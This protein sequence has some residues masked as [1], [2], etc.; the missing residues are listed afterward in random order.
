MWKQGKFRYTQ[1]QFKATRST[2]GDV[3]HLC[4]NYVS[5]VCS[6]N[7]FRKPFLYIVCL[8]FILYIFSENGSFLILKLSPCS[9]SILTY[10]HRCFTLYFHAITCI[11]INISHESFT[12]YSW[13]VFLLW[14]KSQFPRMAVHSEKPSKR[15]PCECTENNF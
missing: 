13:F 2:L 12:Q 8:Y 7:M 14:H 11:R 9:F 5:A 3:I 4:Q 10:P 1:C 6:E 15:T